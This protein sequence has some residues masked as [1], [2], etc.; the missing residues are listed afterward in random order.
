VDINALQVINSLYKLGITKE[1]FKRIEEEVNHTERTGV[2]IAT[3]KKGYAVC[4]LHD[5]DHRIALRK[6]PNAKP[7]SRILF[8]TLIT[9]DDL[10]EQ[11]YILH[12]IGQYRAKDNEPKYTASNL[13]ELKERLLDRFAD[14][15]PKEIGVHLKYSR[16]RYG[17]EEFQR[18][19]KEAVYRELKALFWL[20]GE[21]FENFEIKETRPEITQI[22]KVWSH[23]N[24]RVALFQQKKRWYGVG[25]ETFWVKVYTPRDDRYNY[26]SPNREVV[27]GYTEIWLDDDLCGKLEP[28]ELKILKNRLGDGHHILTADRYNELKSSIRLEIM[29]ERRRIIEQRTR[30][31]FIKRV[32]EQFRAG[33]VVRQGIE[34]TPNSISYEGLT[35]R[36]DRLG[37]YVVGE[38]IILQERPNFREIYERYIDWLLNYEVVYSYNRY[39][40]QRF[41]PRFSGEAKISAGKL[42]LTL[43]KEGKYFYVKIRGHRP[44]RI[45]KEDVATVLKKALQ[46][47]DR[48][49]DYENFLNLTSRVNLKLQEVL[50]R[51]GVD[52]VVD[53]EPS[54]DNPFITESEK[55][56]ITLPLTR[57][58]GKLYT[59]IGGR[60]YRI[61][62]SKALFE[63]GR[64]V[65][66]WRLRDG[67][68]TR[69][70]RLLY[71]A[72]NGI[73]PEVIGQIIKEGRTEYRKMV[74]KIEAE[75]MKKVKRSLE[76]LNHAVKL[77]KARKVKGGYLVKGE[78]GTI[79]FVDEGLKTWTTKQENGKLV[80]DKYLCL[81]DVETD[82]STEWGRNDAIAKRLL[83]LSKDKRVA[84]EIYENGDRMDT[85]WL[86]IK[87]P[88][89]VEA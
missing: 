52:F 18:I 7:N 66:Y 6:I 79:Y 34:F 20:F 27:L 61:K 8:K 65:D 19:Y 29:S 73:S 71:R 30:E 59:M 88:I 14:G 42:H 58:S 77:T 26:V 87:E 82:T 86:D 57:R 53:I 80:P 11:V 9:F 35:I 72:I 39:D 69:T 15:Y 60:E 78:S 54:D 16:W 38:H 12:Q 70:V 64:E 81:L 45:C 5:D 24:R 76:F 2:F 40:I 32:E 1:E 83:A 41:V 17:E 25:I 44:H 75:R 62:N 56:L 33:R 47:A 10:P 85:W 21:D 48:P 49:A 13:E 67:K 63:I 84:D 22:V 23:K 89:E 74:R 50:R 36:G 68:L 31:E 4:V 51:G 55:I 28:E 43:T 3:V 46:Y 37:E